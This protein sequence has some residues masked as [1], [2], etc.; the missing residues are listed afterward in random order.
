M[1]DREQIEQIK[2]QANGQMP[3]Q[4]PTQDAIDQFV[5]NQAYLTFLYYQALK[6]YGLSHSDALYL[7]ANAN[8]T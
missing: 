5:R 8:L 2:R 6:E 7:A 1:N 4:P 3:V